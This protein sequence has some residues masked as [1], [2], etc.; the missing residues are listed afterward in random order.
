MKGRKAKKRLDARR[1]DY[2]NMLASVVK[3]PHSKRATRKQAGGYQMPG[4]FKK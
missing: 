2:T 1:Q 4:S 3:D